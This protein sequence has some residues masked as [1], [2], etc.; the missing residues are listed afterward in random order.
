MDND[1]IKQ[2]LTDIFKN[3][4][5]EQHAELRQKLVDAQSIEERIEIAKSYTNEGGSVPEWLLESYELT[6]DDLEQIAGG[7]GAPWDQHVTE[8]GCD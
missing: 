2:K 4:P 6:D 7:E 8:Y 1:I 5:K 3:V